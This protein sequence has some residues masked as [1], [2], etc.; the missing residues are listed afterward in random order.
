MNR[1]AI[2]ASTKPASTRFRKGTT[3]TRKNV[4]PSPRSGRNL[5]LKT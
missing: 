1:A 5:M 2:E 3:F 4:T